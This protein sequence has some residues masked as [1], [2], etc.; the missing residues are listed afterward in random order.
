[1]NAD[2]ILLLDTFFHVVVFHGEK[3]S[4]WRDQGYQDHEDHKHFKD[5]LVAPKA[6][7]QRIM[8]QRFPVPRFI[9]CDQHKSESRFVIAKLNPSVTHNTNDGSCT[10]LPLSLSISEYDCTHTM[11]CRREQLE[12]GYSQMT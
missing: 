3:I 12:N 2:T 5:L 9:V 1:M 7:A 10:S 11:P 4:M 6:D 8:E